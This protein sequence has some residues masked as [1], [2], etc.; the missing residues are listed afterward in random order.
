[1]S[2]YT[3]GNDR[4]YKLVPENRIVIDAAFKQ[5]VDNL[6]VQLDGGVVREQLVDVLLEEAERCADACK[7]ETLKLRKALIKVCI[8]VA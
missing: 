1:M 3:I 4:A 6:T 8:E 2:N 7:E 5:L